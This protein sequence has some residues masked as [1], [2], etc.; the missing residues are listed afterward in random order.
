MSHLCHIWFLLS[1]RGRKLVKEQFNPEQIVAV[2]IP[3]QEA[4]S[5]SLRFKKEIPDVISFT[6]ILEERSF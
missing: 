6:K 4:E 1:E 3:P 2:H 5:I